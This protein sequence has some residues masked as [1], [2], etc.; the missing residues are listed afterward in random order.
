MKKTIFLLLALVLCLSLCACGKAKS[1]ELDTFNCNPDNKD[2]YVTVSVSA[3]AV[4]NEKKEGS[5]RTAE[6]SITIFVKPT[7]VG[8]T[9]IEGVSVKVTVPSPWSV[10]GASDV[11]LKNGIDGGWY[12]KIPLKA[13]SLLVNTSID[14]VS[15]N[16][17]SVK[18]TS[19]S[20]THYYD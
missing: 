9:E 20:G 19:I 11:Q 3:S 12:A 18:I 14:K 16:E 7:E 17:V 10:V 2:P 6:S 4:A 15:E 1:I 13:E 8:R 5:T